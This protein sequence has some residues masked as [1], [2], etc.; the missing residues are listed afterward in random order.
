MF[1]NGEILSMFPYANIR[2][3]WGKKRKM[4]AKWLDSS[5]VCMFLTFRVC[6][7]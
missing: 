6:L 1:F 4:R 3:L 2:F 7:L 5:S